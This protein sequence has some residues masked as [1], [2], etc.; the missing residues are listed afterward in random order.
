M[1]LDLKKFI[2]KTVPTLGLSL[3]LLLT[4]T[5]AIGCGEAKPITKHNGAVTVYEQK[6]E[7]GYYYVVKGNKLYQAQDA[8]NKLNLKPVMDLTE[9]QVKELEKYSV[10]QLVDQEKLSKDVLDSEFVYVKDGKMVSITRK[11]N[12]DEKTRS[13]IPAE[14]K[15]EVEKALDGFV[16]DLDTI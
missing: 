12:K 11:M 3:I 16:I 15:A 14:I 7:N 4:G 13:E 5:M 1:R 2:T 8:A 10:G 9:A 6:I